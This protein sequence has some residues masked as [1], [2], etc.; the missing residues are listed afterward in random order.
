M[1]L[2]DK[3]QEVIDRAI[4]AVHDRT[5]FAQ[6]PEHP[7]A[8]GKEASEAGQK[9]YEALLNQNFNRLMQDGAGDYIGEEESPYTRN[10]LGIKYPALNSGELLRR[11]EEGFKVWRKVS[12]RERAGLLAETLERIRERFFELAHATMHTTGQSFMM[13]FQASGPHGNDRALEAIALGLY[14][15]ERFPGRAKWTKPM[16]KMEVTLNKEWKPVP[17]GISLAV[18]VSTFPVWN[19]VPGVY[20]SLVT[21]N[22]VIIKP[23]PT[24]ILP[25]AIEVAEIQKVLRENDYPTDIIQLA[26]DTPDKQI[27]RELAED[28]RVKLIDYTG[29]TRFGDYIENLE[30]NDKATFTEKAGVNSVILDSVDDLKETFQNL[31]F[32]LCLYSGQMCTAPQNIFLPSGGIRVNGEKKNYDEVVNQLKESIEGLVKH[33]KMGGGTLGAIQSQNTCDRAESS[34]KLGGKV[35]MEPVEIS[36]PDFPGARLLTPTMIEIDPGK[37]DLYSEELFGPVILVIKTRDTGHAIELAKELSRKKGAITCSAYSTDVEIKQK[38]KEEMEQ[39]FVPVSFNFKGPVWV[40]QNAAFSDFHLTG[41]NPAGN[42]SFT[43]PA[44][45][46]KRFVWVGH[47]EVV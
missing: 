26:V 42:A 36:N 1:S 10:K 31:S 19:T 15:Q 38:I 5:F 25:V 30:N 21:G 44:F 27:T 13:S 29:S 40:N 35:L 11:A 4:K 3:H 37:K 9:N 14:E 7:K 12:P 20:A 18:G 22:P 46:I 34:G 41:G 32:S 45:V 33:P 24:A 8:Y 43:D 6:Y 16:G 28:N 23:H 17:K 2:Y 39:V 47:K